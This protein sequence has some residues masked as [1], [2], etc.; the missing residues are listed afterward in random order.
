MDNIDEGKVNKNVNSKSLTVSRKTKHSVSSKSIKSDKPSVDKKVEDSGNEASSNGKGWEVLDEKS[1]KPKTKVGKNISRTA[2]PKLNKKIV[3]LI[4][5]IAIAINVMICGYIFVTSNTVFTINFCDDNGNDLGFEIQANGG[6]NIEEVVEGISSEKAGHTFVGWYSGLDYSRLCELPSR[7]PRSNITL[8]GKWT[9]NDY[10]VTIKYDANTS[11][12][13]VFEVTYNESLQD[14]D[15]EFNPPT[16]SQ[17]YVVRYNTLANGMGVNYT[18]ISAIRSDITLYA[19]W[20]Y[21]QYTVTFV[22]DSETSDT[23]SIRY[24]QTI[25]EDA[26]DLLTD[27]IAV[28]AGMEA[29]W[30]TASDGSGDDFTSDTVIVGALTVYACERT[31]E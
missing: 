21:V 25:S 22:Y 6:N 28:G 7:M 18:D 16:V 5:A 24:N 17:Q 26:L 10:T 14:N 23:A 8:Y 27:A 31:V 19:I 15:Y 20:D 9:I 3:F 4:I 11:N 12:D 29:Y 13:S 30:N 2:T 1:S